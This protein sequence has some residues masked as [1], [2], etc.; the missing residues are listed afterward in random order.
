MR[1][2]LH[3]FPD[4]RCREI[5]QSQKAGMKKGHS[6]LLV[7]ETVLPDVGCSGF[8]SLTDISRITFSSMQRSEKQWAAL[9]GS[10]GLK[11]VKIWP[12]KGGP[13]AVIESE[14]DG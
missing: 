2:V 5:L 7:C 10:V 1:R 8:D 4:S 9:L 11:I 14:I 12:A 6:K 13:F 3:D